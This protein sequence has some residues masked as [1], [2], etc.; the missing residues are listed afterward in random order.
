MHLVSPARI[1]VNGASLLNGG[2]DYGQIFYLVTLWVL[3]DLPCAVAKSLCLLGSTH[4]VVCYEL[5]SPFP[6]SLVCLSSRFGSDEHFRFAGNSS[7][8]LPGPLA[9]QVPSKLH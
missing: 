4:D 5:G 8:E 9:S 2:R 7:D 3:Q 6:L 1:R